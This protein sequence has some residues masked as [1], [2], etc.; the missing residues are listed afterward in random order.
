MNLRIITKNHAVDSEEGFVTKSMLKP[1]SP[2]G[3]ADRVGFNLCIKKDAYYNFLHVGA[4]MRAC[5][6]T[7]HSLCAVPTLEE[8]EW[9]DR[10]K[11]PE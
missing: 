10:T 2:R 3:H 1:Y 7:E 9:S 4:F 8:F 11:C 5:T 6:F